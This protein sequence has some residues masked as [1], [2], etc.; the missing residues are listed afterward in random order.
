MFIYKNCIIFF[1][2]CTT[3][4]HNNYTKLHHYFWPRLP[5]HQLILKKPQWSSDIR[6]L[7][8][9]VVQIIEDYSTN[10]NITIF[11][12]PMYCS[13]STSTSSKKDSC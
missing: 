12:I 3:F 10:K 9:E 7:P 6:F 13:P 8:E 1:V 5:S 2:V 11:H 4:L